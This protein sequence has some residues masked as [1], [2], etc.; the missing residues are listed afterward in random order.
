MMT[1]MA[2]VAGSSSSCRVA[3]MPSMSGIR[4]SIKMTSGECR[5]PAATASVPVPASATTSM[6]VAALTS[7][8]KP[9]RTRTWS[10]AMTTRMVMAGLRIQTR[11]SCEQWS[12]GWFVRPQ[13]CS[14]LETAAVGAGPQVAVVQ[15]CSLAHADQPVTGRGVRFGM[16]SPW[17]GG[18]EGGDLDEQF[19]GAVFD[20]EGGLG[21]AGMADDVGEGFLGDAIGRQVHSGRERAR[22]TTDVEAQVDAGATGLFGQRGDVGQPWGGGECGVDGVLVAEY[23]DEQPHLV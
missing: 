4:M 8:L 21:G 6:S 23:L 19:P 13:Q 9:A 5:R 22:R 20:A 12:R 3:S 2:L 1:R 18:A 7:T 14:H 15:G 17:L 16:R 11:A 10:S